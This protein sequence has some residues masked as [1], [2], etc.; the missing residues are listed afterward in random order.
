MRDNDNTI[1][2]NFIS[3]NK[4]AAVCCTDGNIPYCFH[5][6]YVFDPDNFLLFFKSSDETWHSKL[7][8]ENAAVAGSILPQKLELLALKGIQFTGTVLYN[9]IPDQI[10]PETFY[11]KRLPLGLAKP[12]HVFCIQLE[13]IKMTDN[14]LVFGKKLLW[15]ITQELV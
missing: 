9:G 15:N 5:C 4:I 14:S 8:A 2:T 6:F 13:S 1:I 7:L 10:K 11:H 3:A 12:G